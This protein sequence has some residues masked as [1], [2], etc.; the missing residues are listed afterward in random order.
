MG[1]DEISKPDDYINGHGFVD[2]GLPS[3]NLWATCNVLAKEPWQTGGYFGWGET[4]EKNFYLPNDYPFYKQQNP[5]LTYNGT[6]IDVAT[7]ERGREW[8]TPT[9]ADWLEIVGPSFLFFS[10]TSD[11]YEY[12][13]FGISDKPKGFEEGLCKYDII[14]INGI[15]GTKITGP[16]GKNIFLPSSGLKT[17]SIF[18]LNELGV[19]QCSSLFHNEEGIFRTSL[20]DGIKKIIHRLNVKEYVPRVEFRTGDNAMIQHSEKFIAQR[21]IEIEDL[22]KG[23]TVRPIIP[24]K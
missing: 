1:R 4:E 8:Q 5:P 22:Y 10:R 2:L 23:L 21:R 14:Q 17:T 11:Y 20:H 6:K 7:A 13:D 12:K 24:I 19:Y 9:L 15:R 3:G 18:Y 16:N